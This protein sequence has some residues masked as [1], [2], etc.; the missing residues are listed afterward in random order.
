MQAKIEANKLLD[1]VI[2][3]QSESLFFWLIFRTI[4]GHW[5]GATFDDFEEVFGRDH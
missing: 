3:V 5:Y 1:L 4:W 2:D